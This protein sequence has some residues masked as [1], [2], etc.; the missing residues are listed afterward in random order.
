MEGSGIKGRGEGDGCDEESTTL[1]ANL[2]AVLLVVVW[3]CNDMKRTHALDRVHFLYPQQLLDHLKKKTCPPSLTIWRPH[4]TFLLA[5]RY[6]VNMDFVGA[7]SLRRDR[8]RPTT[9]ACARE[10]AVTLVV[11]AVMMVGTVWG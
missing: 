10:P 3:E 6:G 7:P 8:S 11:A 5:C 9:L 1:P 2:M 4:P